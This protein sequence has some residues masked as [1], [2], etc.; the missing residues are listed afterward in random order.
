[1]LKSVHPS[2]LSASKG[3]FDCGHF[4]KT[5]DWLRDRYGVEG[6]VDWS[7]DKKVPIKAPEVEKEV[8]VTEEQEG[9]EVVKG[10]KTEVVENG[11]HGANEFEG[12][13]DEDAIE[14]LNELARSSQPDVVENGGGKS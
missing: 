12:D 10:P 9:S 14:A 8:K 7:L 11:G 1:V 6:E 13:E 5:N 4:R 3:F 2:P